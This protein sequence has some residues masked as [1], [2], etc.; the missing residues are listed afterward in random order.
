[1][2]KEKRKH[3]SNEETTSYGK[4]VALLL[5]AYMR[6]WAVATFVRVTTS[7]GAELRYNNAVALAVL[8]TLCVPLVPVALLIGL[9]VRIAACFGSLPYLHDS[10]HWCLQTDLALLIAVLTVLAR[11]RKAAGGS[12]LRD[13]FVRFTRKEAADIMAHTTAIVR[14]QLLLFYTAAALYKFNE[15]FMHPRYSCAPV[16]LI[17]L[18]E[19]N[20]P[21]SMHHPQF[22]ELVTAA[23]PALILFV[24]AII[25]VLIYL[26]PRI[27][28]SFA[29]IFHWVCNMKHLLGPMNCTSP[30]GSGSVI[31]TT[32]NIT[33]SV[34]VHVD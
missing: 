24:E 18:V 10:Q 6:M 9:C 4:D 17:Q 2:E 23:A 19:A 31:A 13:Q 5:P 1:M 14:I 21:R 12:V 33:H 34:H 28:A 29:G 26:E 22:L 32:H 7:A 30:S 20:L 16:Y 27:G 11:R 15:G 25:P 3:D 8:P